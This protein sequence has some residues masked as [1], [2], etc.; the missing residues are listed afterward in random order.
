MNTPDQPAGLAVPPE[1][2][3]DG[4]AEEH[5]EQRTGPGRRRRRRWWPVALL[6]LLLAA[7]IAL[8]VYLWQVLEEWQDRSDELTT[9]AYDIGEELAVTRGELDGARSE[10]EA[11]RSQLTAAQQRISELAEEKA[12]IGD[13]VATQ[14]QLLDYQARVS[15]AAGKVAEALDL[16]V[17]S[18]QQLIVYLED[19]PEAYDAEELDRFGNE[20]ETL[21]QS[22]T[23]ANI[24]LQRELAR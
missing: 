15:Q 14:N 10:L 12:R 9:A 8:T 6:A 1:T 23:D 11:V 22:A 7:A 24:Q 18:Q 17:R 2:G 20:V 19:D 13:D 4:R 21:C 3:P 5:D 16:C